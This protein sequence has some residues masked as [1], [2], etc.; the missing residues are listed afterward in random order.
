MREKLSQRLGKLDTLDIGVENIP[1]FYQNV[2]RFW[3][4]FS[5]ATPL[6]ASSVLS[7][8]VWYN[9]H[10]TVGNCVINP[11]FLSANNNIFIADFFDNN[12]NVIPWLVFKLNN[13]IPEA[14]H[15]NW[16]QIVDAIPLEW[17]NIVKIDNGCSRQFCLLSPHITFN[18]RML[19]F[20]RL[21]YRELYNIQLNKIVKTPTS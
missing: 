3:S 15:F 13:N 12:G 8:C 7:E 2:L 9:K 5:C 18:A 10:I 19:P 6:T 17:K 16:I 14:K 4:E 21:S 11:S 1:I 20:S